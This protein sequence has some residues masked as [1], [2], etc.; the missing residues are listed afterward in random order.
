MA[1]ESA[2]LKVFEQCVFNQVKLRWQKQRGCSRLG[3]VWGDIMQRP[4]NQQ[5]A[6][7][8]WSLCVQCRYTVERP[9][10]LQHRLAPSSLDGQCQ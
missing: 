8:E 3:K 1:A 7:E 6:R 4:W 10:L 5:K 2:E 9:P